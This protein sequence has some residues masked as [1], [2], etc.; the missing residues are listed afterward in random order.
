[1]TAIGLI[2]ARW[3]SRRFPGKPLVPIAGVP[4]VVRVYRAAARAR[5]LRGLWV[6]TDDDRIVAACR[7]HDVPVR[8]TGPH[9]TG[10]DR[11]AAA[12]AEDDDE[13]VVNIQ[14]EEQLIDP[15]AVEAVLDA[16]RRDPEAPMATAVHPLD[17]GALSDPNQVKAAVGPDGRATAFERR[18]PRRAAAA[19]WQHVGLYAYRR[20]FL[21]TFVSLPATPGERCQGLEQLRALEHGHPIAVARLERWRGP[22][23]DVPADVERV[24][25]AL[26]ADTRA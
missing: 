7:A 11:V 23:V 21:H 20:S 26:R 10:T 13:V 2:P 17:E 15:H 25:A 3:A 19:P 8:R 16:L 18:W 22:S 1:M 5:G 4:M 24:E 9:A 12:S 14:G 6:A